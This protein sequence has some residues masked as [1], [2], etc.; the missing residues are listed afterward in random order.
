MAATIRDVARQAGVSIAT[1]SRVLNRS[2]V[3]SDD[4]QQR[5]HA[6]VQE[7]GYVPNPAAQSLPGRRTGGLGIIVPFVGGEFFSELL[8]SI[9]QTAMQHECVLM[10][11]A[12][13]RDSASLRTVLGSMQKRVDG[14]IVVAPELEAEA[15]YELVMPGTPVVFINTPYRGEGV[16]V[17]NFDNYGG[18]RTSVRHLLE[19]GHR[20]IAFICGPPD[21]CDA[22]ERLEGYRAALAEARIPPDPALEVQAGSSAVDEFSEQAGYDAAHQ[23]LRLEQRPTAIVAANDQ[24]AMGAMAAVRRAGLRIPD[25]IAL[26]GF[27]GLTAAQFAVPALSSVEVPVRQVG[28]MATERVLQRIDGAAGE[29]QQDVVPVQFVARAS[30][31]HQVLLRGVSVG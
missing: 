3:V 16:D 15:V 20:R 11:S 12:S 26:T 1:V 22:T 31:L 29:P 8:T 25:D 27:D 2:A 7:L 13:H 10:I 6:A 14:F 24:S 28:A 18:T 21:A 9:D 23:L 30:S 19:Q 17:I 4:K 5:V